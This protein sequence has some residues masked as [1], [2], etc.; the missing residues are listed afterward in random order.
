MTFLD[1]IKNIIEQYLPDMIGR[2]PKVLNNIANIGDDFADT[3]LPNLFSFDTESA[4]EYIGENIQECYA[5]YNWEYKSEYTP[6][7]LESPVAFIE[8]MFKSGCIE[9]I[10]LMYW[11]YNEKYNNDESSGEPYFEELI[12]WILEGVRATSSMPWYW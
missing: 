10:T 6:E 12:D 11:G 9:L 7:P 2:K 3:Y 8:D 5:F 1:E 4:L